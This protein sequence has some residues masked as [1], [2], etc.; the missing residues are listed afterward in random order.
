MIRVLLAD[1]HRLLHPSVR[2]ILSETNEMVLVEEVTDSYG[3][4]QNC[5]EYYPDILLLSPNLDGSSITEIL[6]SIKENWPSIKILVIL[7]DPEETCVRQLVDYRADGIILKSDKPGKLIEAIYA[8]AQ[9]KTWFSS[10]LVPYLVQPD[11]SNHKNELTDREI[12]V[13]QLL[14]TEKTNV[15]IAQA[16]NISERTVRSHL[17]HIYSKLGVESRVGAVA[18][19]IRLNLISE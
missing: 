5:R 3:L 10:V 13:L 4:Q 18:Q 17:G 11:M 1:Q 19:A 16:L 7:S 15:Q 2:A 6:D 12:D 9:G 8:I 14:V